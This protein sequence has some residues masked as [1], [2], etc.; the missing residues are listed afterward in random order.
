[1]EELQN[2][3]EL[4]ISEKHVKE[5]LKLKD[6]P[7]DV[8]TISLPGNYVFY[9]QTTVFISS[10]HSPPLMQFFLQMRF[11]GRLFILLELYVSGIRFSVLL[12]ATRL[13]LNCS[14]NINL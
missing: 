8:R 4:H 14:S 1:M 10:C 11:A 7:E 12:S 9:R 5:R 2:G 13:S 6:A 3:T